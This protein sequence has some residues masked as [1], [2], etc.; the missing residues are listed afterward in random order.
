MYSRVIE[1]TVE[2]PEEFPFVLDYNDG[3]PLGV[4][5]SENAPDNEQNSNDDPGWAQN[6]IGNGARSSSAVSYLA[7]PFIERPNLHVL[8][9]AQVSRVL[10]ANTSGGNVHFSQVEFSQDM[11]GSSGTLGIGL[12][13]FTFQQSS[14]WSPRQRKS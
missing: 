8:I 10:A 1:T 6:T 11:K 13:I 4:G 3:R 12:L 9:N 14:S 7:T 2:M 5:M